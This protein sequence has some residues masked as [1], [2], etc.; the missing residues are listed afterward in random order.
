MLQATGIP[1]REEIEKVAPPAERMAKGPVAVFECFERIPCD[2]CHSACKSG[3]V[4]PFADINDLP[5]VD[6]DRCNGCGMC[7]AA[8]PGLAVFVVDETYSPTEDLVKVPYEFLPAAKAGD[9]VKLLDRAGC[10]VGE[11]IVR[12]AFLGGGKGKMGTWVVS[13]SVP[14]G[15]GMTVRAIRFRGNSDV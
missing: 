15:L 3:A 10:V 8:C 14:K 5:Q 6:F 13:V 4:K 7:V 2:P 1:T 11:G 12:S 9:S